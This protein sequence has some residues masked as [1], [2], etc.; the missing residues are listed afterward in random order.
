MSK[1]LLGVFLTFISLQSFSATVKSV[2]LDEQKENLLIGV[3]YGGGCGNHE[4]SLKLGSCLETY[5]VQ[6][7]AELIE[8]TDDTCEALIYNTITIPLSKYNLSD[9]YFKGGTL[10][11]TGDLDWK[12]NQPSQAS[13]QLP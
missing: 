10:R 6:C 8:Q 9:S 1:F 2:E 11:I 4:F 3:V 7:S 12:T 13:I 5:P